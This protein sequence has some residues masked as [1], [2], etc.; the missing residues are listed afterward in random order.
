MSGM[1]LNVR[2]LTEK[3][4]VKKDCLD[5]DDTSTLTKHLVKDLKWLPLIFEKPWLANSW[6]AYNV[7]LGKYGSHVVT[8]VKRGVSTVRGILR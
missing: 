1:S 7:F 3:I 2:A 5:D 4:L 6:K 8:S